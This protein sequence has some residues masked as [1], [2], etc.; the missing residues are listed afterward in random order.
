M[1]ILT[2]TV[3]PLLGKYPVT[4]LKANSADIVFT[5]AGVNF[6]E[7]FQFAHT[8]REIILVRNGNVAAK[9]ITI[10][11]APNAKGRSGTITAYSVGASEYAAFPPF[12]VDGW[13][14]SS[15]YMT[16]AMSAADMEIAVLRLPD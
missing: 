2:V 13:R 8:G 16:G 4:P 14:Q 3:Q 10:N 1:A 7:G 5:P 11:S 12:P 15:G 9:T 6:A